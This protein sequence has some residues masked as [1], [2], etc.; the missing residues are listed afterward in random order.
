M[1]DQNNDSPQGNG[2]GGQVDISALTGKVESLTKEAGKYKADLE[3][4]QIKVKELEGQTGGL[5]T[6]Q[7]QAV[8][9]A[10]AAEQQLKELQ[11]QLEGKTG[12]VTNWATQHQQLNEQFGQT[13]TQLQ[14]TQAELNLYKMIADT[15]EYH[16]LIGMVAGI[17]VAGT[18]EDQK[19]ILDAMAKGMKGHTDQ[20]LNVFKGGGTPPSPAGGSPG[21][22]PGPAAGPKNIQEA[23]MRLNQIMGIPGHEAEQAQLYAYIQQQQQGGSGSPN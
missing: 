2:E 7:K 20:M 5:T 19:T 8:E 18:P 6:A 23:G 3:A 1:A 21:T 11:K 4:A 13:T 12:E 17:K 22:N 9:R 16:G 10:T 15:P 14:T